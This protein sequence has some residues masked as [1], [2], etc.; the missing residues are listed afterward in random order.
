MCFH[1]VPL[2]VP[3]FRDAQ[4]T[5][6]LSLRALCCSVYC[7]VIASAVS[8]ATDYGRDGRIAGV[9]VSVG[10]RFFS[11]QRRPDRF[12]GPSSLLSNGY[13]GLFLRE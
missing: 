6:S 10:A 11:P 9:R 13:E 12:R 8:R 5:L 4:E 2:C 7:L 1:A 3:T